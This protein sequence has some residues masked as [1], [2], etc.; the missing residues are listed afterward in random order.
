MLPVDFELGEPLFS[1][2]DTLTAELDPA[3]T[4]LLLRKATRAFRTEINDMLLA[5]LVLGFGDR[6]GKYTLR[7][8]LEGHGREEIDP[9]I[10]LSRTVGW[11][12]SIYPVTLEIEDPDDLSSSLKLI[13]EELRAIPNKGMGFG[14]LRYLC[15]ASKELCDLQKLGRS[16]IS[17]NYLGQWSAGKN[18]GGLFSLLQ[19]SSNWN[20][21][22]DNNVSHLLNI[23][24]EVIDKQLK[25]HWSYSKNH[26]K[27]ETIQLFADAFIKRL[28]DL[29]AHCV[30]SSLFGYTP[31]DFPLSRLNQKTI[32]QV[33][34]SIPHL[35]D[36]YPLSPLQEGLLFND[37]LH[38]DRDTYFIQTGFELEGEIN[39]S[40]I[41]LAWEQV[42]RQ[43]DVLRTGFQWQGLENP[44]QF[45]LQRVDLPWKLYDWQE[46]SKEIQ[47]IKLQEYI[48]QDRENRFELFQPPLMRLALVKLSAKKF[49]LIWSFHHLI[50]DGWSSALIFNQLFASLLKPQN[51]HPEYVPSYRSYIEKLQQLPIDQAKAFWVA[52]LSD[53]SNK[54]LFKSSTALPHHKT[55]SWELSDSESGS[56]KEFARKNQLTLSSVMQL[57]W[58]VALAWYFQEDDFIFGVTIS[59]RSL[60]LPKI[61]QM[62]GLFINTLPFRFKIS[63]KDRVIDAIQQLQEEM[64][65]I[66]RFSYTPLSKVQSFCSKA[67][68]ARKSLFDQIFIFEN[69]PFNE[70]DTHEKGSLKIKNT[71]NKE[72]TEYPLMLSVTPASK[73]TFQFTYDENSVEE[74]ILRELSSLLR[75]TL[76][77]IIDSPQRSLREISILEEAETN[78]LLQECCPVSIKQIDTK[79]LHN[80]FEEQC[81]KT[82]DSVSLVS[83]DVHLT[84]RELNAKANQL[85][86]Q[87][88]KSGI[89]HEN[90]VGICAE[91]S[92]GFIVA[93]LGVLKAGGMYVPMDPQLPQDRLSYILQDANATLLLIQSEFVEQ[94]QTDATPKLVIDKMGCNE[95]EESIENP[96]LTIHPAQLAYILYTSGSTGKPKGVAIQHRS[97][98]N[99]VYATAKLCDVD[100]ADRFLAVTSL[101]FDVSVLDYFLPLAL[102][103]STIIASEE[104]RKNPDQLIALIQNSEITCM[105]ATPSAW[106]MLSLA[107]WKQQHPI[108]MFVAGEKLSHHISDFL[109]ENGAVFNIYGPTEGTIYATGEEILPKTAITIGRALQNVQAIVLDKQ[110]RPKAKGGIGELYLGGICLARGYW[111]K[112]QLTADKFVPHPFE[113]GNRLY[114]TGDAVRY[115]FAGEIDYIGRLDDQ[116]KLRGFRIELGEIESVLEEYPDTKNAVVVLKENA[117]G[118]KNLAA[119]LVCTQTEEKTD[120]SSKLRD[121]LRSRLPDYMVPSIFVFLDKIPLTASGK[122]NR[123][124]LPEPNMH[125][126]HTRNEYVAPR[127]EIERSLQEVWS[128]LLGTKEIGVQDNFFEVGGDSIISIQLVSKA[129]QRGLSIEIKQLFQYPTIE[130][131]ALIVKQKPV[132]RFR[133]A[134]KE[135]QGDVLL[136]PIQHWFFAQNLVNKNHYNQSVLLEIRGSIQFILVE[137]ALQYLANYHECFR[138]RFKKTHEGW[139]QF[140]IDKTSSSICEHVI[141]CPNDDFAKEK[142]KEV[143]SGLNIEN[144]P[145]IRAVL[146]EGIGK[147]KLCIAIHHLVIDGVS[148]RILLEDLEEAYAQL[149]QGKPITLS[150]KTSSYQQWSLALQEYAHSKELEAE[151]EYWSEIVTELAAQ[152]IPFSPKK[153]EIASTYALAETITGELS[154]EQTALLLHQTPKAYRT[155]MNDV[156]L[157]ALVYAF[158]NST[159]K[160][161][162]YLNLEG[163][164]REEQI[165]EVDLS[166]TV[167]WFTSIFPIRLHLDHPDDISHSLKQVKEQMRQ[168]PNKGIGYG[169]LRYLALDM[170]RE[171]LSTPH[172][173]FNY[174]GQW[175]SGK[176]GRERF[177]LT[178]GT[179]GYDIDLKNQRPHLIDINC[180]V[181]NDRFKV[182]FS[183][184]QEHYHDETIRSVLLNFMSQ[185]ERIVSHCISLESPSYTPSDFPLVPL[186]QREL[187]HSF[188]A[189]YKD[190]QTIYPLSPMQQ[191]MLFRARF[192]PNSQEYFIQNGLKIE[193]CLDPTS[194]CT[195]WESVVSRHAILRTAF[196][197]N[198]LDEPLQ[199]VLS[200]IVLPY[201][202][203][204]LS[205]VSSEQQTREIAIYEQRD[206]DKGFNLGQVPLFRLQLF[207]LSDDAHY[208]VWS[209]HHILIDGW[210]SAIIFRDLRILYQNIIQ[211]NDKQ[212][213]PVV[214]SYEKYIEWMRKQN[215][216]QAKN[217]WRSYLLGLDDVALLNIQ[218]PIGEAQYAHLNFS[219]SEAESESI[220]NLALHEKLTLNSLLI[221]LWSILVSGIL[222]HHDFTIGVTLSGRSVELEGIDEMAGLFINTVP[223]RLQF[224]NRRESVVA[225]LHRI[226]ADIVEINQHAYLTLADIQSLSSISE[227]SLFDHIFIFEN[228]PSEDSPKTLKMKEI[229]HF[230]K[231]E[232]PLTVCV[233]PGRELSFQFGFNTQFF[234]KEKIEHIFRSLRNII[235]QF[236]NHPSLRLYEISLI[237]P[238]EKEQIKHESKK[239]LESP[240][241]QGVH[242]LFEDQTL[243]TPDAVAICCGEELLTYSELNSRAN[244]LAKWLR[245]HGVTPDSCVGICLK[246]TPELIISILGTLKAG[247][248]YLPIDADSPQERI[249]FYLEDS[250][251]KIVLTHSDFIHKFSKY[252]GKAIPLD[253]IWQELE[254]EDPANP[255]FK[256]NPLQLAYVIYTSGSTGKPK[257]V[258]VT[259]SNFVH[260]LKARLSDYAGN[261]KVFLL[262]LS[263]TFDTCSAGIFWTLIQGGRLVLFPEAIRHIHTMLSVFISRY[264]VT[265]FFCVPALYSSFLEQLPK[266]GN[267]EEVI[268]GGEIL[269]KTLVDRHKRQLEK[270]KLF[271]EYGPTEATVWSTFKQIYAP[272][273][274]NS[275]ISIGQPISNVQALILSA[276]MEHMPLGFKGEIC[277]GGNGIARGYLN[278]KT[279][280][281]EKFAPNPFMSHP[282]T[283]LYKT[284]DL[285]T[286]L[287]NGELDYVGRT[288]NQI[289]LRGYRLELEEIQHAI[290]QRGDVLHSLVTLH[291]EMSMRD[292][293]LAYVAHKDQ[294]SEGEKASKFIEELRKYVTATLPPYMVPNAFVLIKEFPL[295]PTGKIDR[296]K[297]PKPDLKLENSSGLESIPKTEV[298]EGLLN[299]WCDV[300]NRKQISTAENFF[301]IGGHSLLATKLVAKIQQKYSIELL[302]SDIF[303]HPTIS[304][305]AA[306]IERQ[307][308]SC[309]PEIQPLSNKERNQGVPLSYAQQRLWFLDQLIQKDGLYNISL[310]IRVQGSLDHD[311]LQKAFNFL[312]NRHEIL[313][314]EI[315]SVKGIS[316]QKPVCDLPLALV[317]EHISGKFDVQVI[318]EEAYTPFNLSQPPLIRAKAWILSDEEAVLMFTMHHIVS[319]GW[320]MGILI[321]ELSHCYNG[322]KQHAAPSLPPLPIQYLDFANWQRKWLESGILTT[323]LAFWKENLKGIPD[324]ITLPYDKKR[325][326]QP[327]FKGGNVHYSLSSSQ[328]DSINLLCKKHGATPFM[329]LLTAFQ[330]LLYRYSGQSNVVVGT[331]VANRHYP[332]VQDLIGFFVNTLAIHTQIKGSQGFESVLKIVR[333]NLIRIFENQDLPFE[334]IVE[335]LDMERNAGHHPVFQTMF[336]YQNEN[337]PACRLDGLNVQLLD[338]ETRVAKFDLTLTAT[339]LPDRL[340]LDIEYALDLFEEKTILRMMKHFE[341][342]INSIIQNPKKPI[343]ALPLL[344]DEENQLLRNLNDSTRKP[345]NTSLI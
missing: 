110:L 24:G 179:T 218:Q 63:W 247:G 323:Q 329:F 14:V 265:N 263:V 233:V 295:T 336:I 344:T 23:N 345:A 20:D 341:T 191:G 330:V 258:L 194:F 102:G 100:A 134:K 260:S 73:I 219:F 50:L 147:Q 280:T 162:L 294:I 205:A 243:K 332:N 216:E 137:K 298:E 272:F 35:Q 126:R 259:H 116:V 309:Y 278:R 74:K 311:A 46:F 117:N 217:F 207:R 94:F 123:Q 209:C 229:S 103:G 37:L 306:R 18:E 230:E 111:R 318:E 299:I 242:G 276:S 59:G 302:I 64:V 173:S 30:S 43:H 221:G 254:L 201:A 308:K 246:R 334:H 11:F 331:P 84:Y 22:P 127:T 196:A 163:H 333:E 151:K 34:S 288:D 234:T 273:E 232:F 141:N 158:A 58:G 213:L 168:I 54:S 237:S 212:A 38:S 129:R 132:S 75:N 300:L 42:V 10:D 170:P 33:F 45:V 98:I 62:V 12:T 56:V 140:Y 53:S 236:I 222:Q 66:S 314:T 305:L 3:T 90:P 227:G 99:C 27:R 41:K 31:S 286:K 193:G 119:Y 85:A 274:E 57:A 48:A 1:I 144:G 289:K 105:Q 313:R 239:V 52:Y 71:L 95:V 238:E 86:H 303:E 245:S 268:L 113:T 69:Y 146:F 192:R 15:D 208:F 277:I 231:T 133:E 215:G 296:K 338:I 185:L 61:D 44:L 156:L 157:T 249:Q 291:P 96:D 72:H 269:Q 87:L 6:T 240:F 104:A 2:V 92:L 186:T 135:T 292:S 118:Q 76:Q 310:A 225:F 131:L 337:P 241:V 198:N 210:S 262:A 211:S 322:Y 4:D 339:L 342:L 315:Q 325:P 154:S 152:E 255:C 150:P 267:L 120:L 143:A 279:L 320:S 189:Y 283:R 175:S 200:R 317:F 307:K 250:S 108:K 121:Y 252:D 55:F 195:A 79:C 199:Y 197:W 81:R 261:V 271:N 97:V 21:A 124:A 125:T 297:L 165:G 36:I 270:V 183:Y 142:M 122:V 324:F 206:R 290:N 180:E 214:K 264:G 169:I 107:K 182:Y 47:Q 171:T 224:P 340:A 130:Q 80:L 257:G 78:K 77:G 5:A 335:H 13:K 89:S 244:Q 228:Y 9:N 321:N 112:P 184:S 115:L 293:L 181:I 223:L 188:G 266:Q 160:H 285:A 138:L 220:K 164:G 88:I 153:Q 159:G 149:E 8:D 248:A 178:L 65:D 67:G 28:K 148:W 253:K 39:V 301:H 128:E 176:S 29:V 114:K 83:G 26:F 287:P 49:F 316:L 19:T 282:G 166:R 187:D 203:T 82:P 93:I 7:I 17:F 256:M 155:Q 312:V 60:D 68:E 343:G 251:T 172:I 109:L 40:T 319:D 161:S 204:D 51:Y 16:Q 136:T 91:R 25:V 202:Y 281:A 174:L 177:A 167:G 145:L 304:G 101:T 70:S 284:G 328:V 190:L 32:D 226:Q 275:N 235:L 106:K 326:S 327:S 139:H